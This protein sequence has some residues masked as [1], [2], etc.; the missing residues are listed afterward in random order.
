MRCLRAASWADARGWDREAKFSGRALV[1]CKWKMEVLRARRWSSR[2]I[3]RQVRRVSN[4]DSRRRRW[5]VV[6][7]VGELGEDVV[8]ALLLRERL[9]LSLLVGLHCGGCWRGSRSRPF[10]NGDSTHGT[11][12][13]AS[14][15][16][17]TKTSA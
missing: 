13:I 3:W 15:A 9:L 4:C 2:W 8:L 7:V 5:T 10:D 17:G 1:E 14:L 12:G 11:I 16:G 6:V